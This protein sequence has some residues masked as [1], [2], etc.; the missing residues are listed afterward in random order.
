MQESQILGEE[1]RWFERRIVELIAFEMLMTSCSV[2]T[3][4][5]II[6]INQRIIKIKL[7]NKF[8]SM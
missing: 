5:L 2:L 3:L 7:F 1:E 8:V 4:F 6:H